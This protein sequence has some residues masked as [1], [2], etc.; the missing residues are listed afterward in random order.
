[1]SEKEIAA[2]AEN[3]KLIVNGYA[4]SM[5]EDFGGGDYFRN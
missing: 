3:A 1:M 5:R 4:F 2:I